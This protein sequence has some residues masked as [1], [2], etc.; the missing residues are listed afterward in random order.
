MALTRNKNVGGSRK[1][2]LKR[3]D[4]DTSIGFIV[5]RTAYV[6]RQHL[7]EGFRK[8]NQPITPEEFALLRVLWNQDGRR[9]GELAD[10]AFKD[11]TTV[12]RLI[13]GL[14]GKG[15]VERKNDQRDRRAVRT[16]LTK[17]GKSLEG[18]LVPI[19][20]DLVNRATVDVSQKDLEITLETLRKVQASLAPPK[21]S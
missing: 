5:N 16:W 14:V 1:P 18:K 9:Q 15:L 8:I 2:P 4:I 10:Y 6:M 11:R 3:F 20:H 19:A 21:T 17:T 12:T 13:D 7:H